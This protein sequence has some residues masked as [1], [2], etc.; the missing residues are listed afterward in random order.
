MA[1]LFKIIKCKRVPI[2]DLRSMGE[3]K[4]VFGVLGVGL[5]LVAEI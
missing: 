4:G 1:D 3:R 5:M 2:N